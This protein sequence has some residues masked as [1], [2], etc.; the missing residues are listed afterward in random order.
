MKNYTMP[1]PQ[2]ATTMRLNLN[3]LY[4]P[5]TALAR[6]EPLFITSDGV[7]QSAA[8][9]NPQQS[10]TPKRKDLEPFYLTVLHLNNLVKALEMVVD[11]CNASP[12]CQEYRSALV[13]VSEAVAV[14]VEK[15]MAMEP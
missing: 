4:D 9:T 7:D 15:L 12:N 8:P 1:T 11:D 6:G 5:A 13:G 10:H 14:E 2:D 3:M